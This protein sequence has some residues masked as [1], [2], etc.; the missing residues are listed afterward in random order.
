M[1]FIREIYKGLLKILKLSKKV[2]TLKIMKVMFNNSWKLVKNYYIIILLNLYT[3]I[4]DFS[5]TI[6]QKHNLVSQK[7][8][9]KFYLILKLT[10]I[11][12]NPY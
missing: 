1:Q 3:D 6:H 9:N 11:S 4:F 8:S 10:A 2:K 5:L 12:R 7:S